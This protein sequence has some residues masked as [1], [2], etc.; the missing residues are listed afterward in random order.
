MERTPRLFKLI[1]LRI[2]CRDALKGELA[3]TRAIVGRIQCQQLADLLEREPGR[4]G[5][6]DE[7]EAARVVSA[8]APDTAACAGSVRSFGL[9]EKPATLIVAHGLD[10]YAAFARKPCDRHARHALTP[11]YGTDLI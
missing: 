7:T 10:P 6:A 8:V 11:D 3:R 9:V 5:G 1:D 2:Q 4:L